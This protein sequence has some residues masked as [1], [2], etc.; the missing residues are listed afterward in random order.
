[1]VGKMNSFNHGG[2]PMETKGQHFYQIG[3]DDASD[4]LAEELR[5]YGMSTS[6][7]CRLLIKKFAPSII[8]GIRAK[9]K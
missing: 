1:M 4:K 8:E 5:E 7:L 6:G 2:L 3:L 9:E